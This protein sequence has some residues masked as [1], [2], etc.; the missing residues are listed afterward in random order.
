MRAGYEYWSRPPIRLGFLLL[1]TLQAWVTAAALFFIVRFGPFADDAWPLRY[2]PI[3]ASL[4]PWFAAC[5]SWW[6]VRK[7]V[8]SGVADRE[9]A[10]FCYSIIFSIVMCAYV[11]VMTIVPLLL[12]PISRVK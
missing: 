2:F 3:L 12:H 7:R 5:T 9:T 11:V 1:V 6:R 8:K 10:G 4:L